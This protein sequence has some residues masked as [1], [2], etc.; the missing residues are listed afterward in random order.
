MITVISNPSG[1]PS[2]QDNLWHIAASDNSGSTGMKFVFD[3]FDGATQLVRV[4]QFP[5]PTTG[6]GYFD[7]GPV[8]RNQITYAWFTPGQTVY[9]KQPSINGEVAKAYTIKYGEE[10]SGITTTNL[11]SATCTA[12]NWVP[13]VFG[14]RQSD[15]SG[16][17]NKYLTDRP[18][19]IE[20]DIADNV[21]V[22]IYTNATLTLKV[23]T[24]D[25]SNALIASTIDASGYSNAGFVQLNIGA[26]AI[27]ARLGTIVTAAVKYYD[28]WFNSFD[29]IR[30]YLKCNGRYEPISLHFMNRY[31]MFDT[32]KFGLVS[33]LT[34]D[35]DRKQYRQRD[36]RFGTNAVTYY[37]TNNVYHDSSVN[38]FNAMDHKYK[39]TMDAPT[40]A[41]YQWL[42]QLIY[43]PQVYAEIGGSYYPISIASNNYEYST[44]VNNRLRP[45]EI[46]INVNQPR[47]SHL[48]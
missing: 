15:L 35:V 19:T 42:S 41:E 9:L 33:R 4:K 43:S 22:P 38:Y 18:A 16:K 17:L 3:I 45:L 26:A 20:A 44:Y 36:Y 1:T 7:A 21:M 29:K 30:V 28:V 11:A 31:G 13:P 14:R 8:V 23:D 39:L 12:F 48:R 40:D 34:M 47:N 37:D 24:F 27:N 10:V 6:R 32:A 5:E 25:A 2:V 46:D